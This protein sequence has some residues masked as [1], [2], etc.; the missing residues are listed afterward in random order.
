M[1]DAGVLVEVAM[2]EVV[3]GSN[4]WC[5]GYVIGRSSV[6]DTG[7]DRCGYSSLYNDDSGSHNCR[8]CLLHA[9][10]FFHHGPGVTRGHASVDFRPVTAA[11]TRA[12]TATGIGN[13][14]MN[15]AFEAI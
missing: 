6:I 12:I 14:L 4:R 5:S 9:R 11:T 7:G 2:V 15:L 13:Y 1:A 8:A 3:K 10:T